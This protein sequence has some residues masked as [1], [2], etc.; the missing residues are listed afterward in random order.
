MR[1][2]SFASALVLAACG[3]MGLGTGTGSSSRG[4]GSTGTTSTGTTPTTSGAS[5]GGSACA[6]D[7]QTGVTLCEQLNAC[8]GVAVDQGTF[9]DCGFRLRGA[10]PIDL[11]CL[12]NGT[13]LCPLGAPTS[14]AT[15]AQL[16]AQQGSAL[17]VCQ[18]LDQ[19]GCLALGG[20][21]AGAP[22][23]LCDR[24]CES[25]CQSDPGCVSL[26]GC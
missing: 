7:P 8:P 14:C 10:G 9:P 3:D 21:D 19:G 4:G 26:C 6:T 12:C 16:L 24:A 25:Q 15:A 22:S 11:E 17:T 1:V 2:I 23:S 5:G 18:Q 13:A 20:A